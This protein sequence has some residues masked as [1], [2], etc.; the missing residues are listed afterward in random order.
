MIRSDEPLTIEPGDIF[1]CFGADAV[2]RFIS[3]E[4]SLLSFPF[5]PAG[6]RLAPSHVAIACPRYEENSGQC[7]WFESTTMT[8]RPCLE[9]KRRVSG[10]QCHRIGDRLEDYLWEGR[11]DVYRLTPINAL[12]GHA[13]NDMRDDLI[14]WFIREE[15]SYDVASAVFS[16]AVLMRSIDKLTGLMVPRFESVFCSQLIAAELM[17]LCR[18]NRD[19]PQ[20]YTPGRL[21]RTLVSQGTYSRIRSLSEQDIEEIRGL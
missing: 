16:G 18:M 7:F 2:S 17:S 6:L 12:C 13:V 21:M 11:V 20:R 10:V 15:V 5:A 4:T 1:A 9:A 3:Y 8:H 14:S 19:N